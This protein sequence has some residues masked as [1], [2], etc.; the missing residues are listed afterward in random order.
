MEIGNRGRDWEEEEKRSWVE[1]ED[2]QKVIRE[3]W[4]GE[5]RQATEIRF[6]DGLT[7]RA[8]ASRVGGCH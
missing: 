7:F 1:G 2:D 6:F 3:D 4:A 5:G 8:G